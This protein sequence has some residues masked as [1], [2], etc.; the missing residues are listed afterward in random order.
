MASIATSDNVEAIERN[1]TTEIDAATD[2]P[3]S[4]CY[5]LALPA[6]LQNKIFDMVV[7]HRAI[8]RPEVIDGVY[9]TRMREPALLSVCRTIRQQLRD[10]YYRD[11][12]F[13]I[14]YR[15]LPKRR[16]GKAHMWPR[17][18]LEKVLSVMD[19]LD[20]RFHLIR[21]MEVLL[22]D[23]PGT[24]DGYDHITFILTFRV[25][26]GTFSASAHER[27]ESV[28]RLFEQVKALIGGDV[29]FEG[30]ERVEWDHHLTG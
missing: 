10:S 4:K 3:S 8:I 28:S 9:T 12:Y 26:H 30:K 25:V 5:L 11:N 1:T 2:S 29:E 16:G 17:F 6:E 13:R 27:G 23:Q 22:S 21:N 15:D 24:D 19:Q 18:T 20:G 7:P 14:G